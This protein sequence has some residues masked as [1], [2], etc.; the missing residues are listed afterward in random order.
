MNEGLIFVIPVSI[1][2]LTILLVWFVK[3]TGSKQWKLK[4]LLAYV[5]ISSVTLVFNATFLAVLLLFF[6]GFVVP[7]LSSRWLNHNVI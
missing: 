6:G 1:L 4:F 2:S 3:G 5:F 7:I